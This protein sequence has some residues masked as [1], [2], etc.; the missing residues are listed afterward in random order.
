M[1]AQAS[2]ADTV[3]ETFTN[4]AAPGTNV[5][6]QM[7]GD[8]DESTWGSITQADVCRTLQVDASAAW[9]GGD[10]GVTA[11][12]SDGTQG[13]KTLT[14]TAGAVVESGYGVV[15]GTISRVRNLGTFGAGTCDVQTGGSLAVVTGGR[16]VTTLGLWETSANGKD[17]T[18]AVSTSGIVTHAA[19]LNG[20][21]DFVL[22]YKL[23]G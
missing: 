1:R 12:W 14:A 4:P 18:G 6:A 15:P 3:V 11:L 8:V 16:T 2:A 5:V 22:A 19:T 13:E 7:A 20:A 21:L 17:A 23:T 10:I 9:D